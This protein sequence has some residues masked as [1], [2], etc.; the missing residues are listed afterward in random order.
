M[1]LLYWFDL[2]S[3]LF[4]ALSGGIIG[5]RKNMDYFG[6]CFLAFIT[7][8]G[9][10]TVRDLLIGAMPI[11]WVSDPT[12]IGVILLGAFLSILPLERLRW[13]ERPFLV[14]D[15]FAIALAAIVGLQKS[16]EFGANP[17]AAVFFGMTSAVIGGVVRDVVCNRVPQV[18]R[19]EIYA[20]ACLAGGVIYLI[21]SQLLDAG[22]ILS[23]A[24]GMGTIVLLRL[25]A[26]R[27]H[28]SLPLVR[29]EGN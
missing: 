17:L 19:Q 23:F 3:V 29:R 7:A 28:W 8:I 21:T 11:A 2:I 4:F 15:T 27:W 5:K 1:T 25:G 12:Y 22:A 20:T 26:I 10:G 14:A 16:L 18:L 24:S 13:I 9:G 6:V